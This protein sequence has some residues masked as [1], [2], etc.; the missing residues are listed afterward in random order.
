MIH[1]ETLRSWIKVARVIAHTCTLCTWTPLL[2]YH[3]LRDIEDSHRATLQAIYNATNPVAVVIIS[4]YIS[5]LIR[6]HG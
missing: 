6:E 2:L 3:F 1:H 5:Y 4:N